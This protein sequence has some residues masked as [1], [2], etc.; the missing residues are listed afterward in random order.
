MTQLLRYAGGMNLTLPAVLIEQLPRLSSGAL[1]TYVALAVFDRAGRL[2]PTQED[3]AAQMNVSP[4]SVMTYL[5]ELER[6][7]YL[8]K[9]RIGAGRKTD[10]V[11]IHHPAYGA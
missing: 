11:L 5:Q 4:R 6:E 1:K 2:Y 7:G 8:E 10:Y 9:R 3:L